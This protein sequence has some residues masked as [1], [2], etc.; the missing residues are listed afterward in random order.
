MSNDH[1][2]TVRRYGEAWA[3]GDAAR[4]LAQLAEIWADEGVYVDAEIPEGV[5]GREA[6][7]AHISESFKELPGLA[8]TATTEV[9]ALGDRAWYRWSATAANE[10]PFTGTDFIEFAPDGRI[11][12]VTN[13]FD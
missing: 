10:E 4:R 11:T 8:I 12:R 7:S 13:F 6:L 3:E 9:A 5:K 2:A 1:T